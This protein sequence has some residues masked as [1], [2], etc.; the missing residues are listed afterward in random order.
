MYF[1]FLLLCRL[2]ELFPH[3]IDTYILYSAHPTLADF[4]S[5][6]WRHDFGTMCLWFL[7]KELSLAFKDGYH[8]D[9]KHE[10]IGIYTDTRACHVVVGLSHITANFLRPISCRNYG[11]VPG[12]CWLPPGGRC[13]L[14][15]H[16]Y[17]FRSFYDVLNI[18]TVSL[19]RYQWSDTTCLLIPGI[20]QS[21]NG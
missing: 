11:L 19:C 1:L 13:N 15:I 5:S 18:Y 6:Y 17:S 14:R 2:T 9:P 10:F 16:V 7:R 8:G 3:K 4:L 21:L 12:T 20:I